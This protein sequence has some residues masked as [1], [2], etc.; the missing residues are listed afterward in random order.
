MRENKKRKITEENRKFNISWESKYVFIEQNG[1]CICLIC[2][3]TIKHFKESN[4]KRH[5][6]RK[7]DD[8]NKEFPFSSKERIKKIMEL[9]ESS[10]NQKK[11]ISEVSFSKR[12]KK[13]STFKLTYNIVKSFRPY[14]EGDFIKKNIIDL[15]KIIDGN[16]Q[17][18]INKIEMIPTNRNTIC[19]KN[20]KISE[21]L[22]NSLLEKINK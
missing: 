18:L 7:H 21:Y 16:N 20:S 13:L 5:F 3:Q 2:L 6:E 8:F 10:N 4:L 12:E 17:R 15:I 1:K 9:K 22:K 19:K 14:S 11:L